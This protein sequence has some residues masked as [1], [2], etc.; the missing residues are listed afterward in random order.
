[1]R[2]GG[3]QEVIHKGRYGKCAPGKHYETLRVE[4]RTAIRN[5]L[6]KDS[7]ENMRCLVFCSCV[8]L[9]TMAHVDLCN[10]LA[11]SAHVSQN[12]KYNNLKKEKKDNCERKREEERGRS[13]AVIPLQNGL[14]PNSWPFRDVQNP[15]KRA[16]YLYLCIN[17]SLDVSCSWR[18]REIG[19]P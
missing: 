2:G 17:Q 15:G 19:W 3:G 8:S 12:L 1:M 9:L 4:P 7:C 18:G 11:R 16:W 6:K 14:Q 10:K 13:W 5:A